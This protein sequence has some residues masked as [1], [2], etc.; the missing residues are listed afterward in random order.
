MVVVKL[1]HSIA[2]GAASRELLERIFGPERSALQSAEPDSEPSGNW[3][4]VVLML[5]G[6]HRT[7]VAL[8]SLFGGTLHQL[9]HQRT[10]TQAGLPRPRTAFSGATPPWG[11]DVTRS[12][13]IAVA[14]LPADSLRR[15]R[16]RYGASTTDVL[17]ALLGGTLRPSLPPGTELTAVV[18][19]NT[20]RGTDDEWGNHSSFSFRTLA[21]DCE[22]P[23]TRIA[24]TATEG[25]V[26]RKRRTVDGSRTVE[27]WWEAY[28]LC[29]AVRVLAEVTMR[30]VRGRV[31]AAA[32]VYTVAGPPSFDAGDA[33]VEQ[34]Y[35][36][37]PLANGILLNVTAWSYKDVL[38]IGVIVCPSDGLD[39]WRIAEAIQSQLSVL[40]R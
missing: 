6:A 16:E 3:Q 18:P 31:T 5:R 23:E 36:I 8:P 29:R 2:D 24:A 21:S 32:I 39:P 22:D 14:E 25:R 26:A 20:R 13:A 9:R 37:G 35:S 4:D 7:M 28:P 34:L 38:S 33:Q 1:H 40:D 15:V 27:T 11:M 19:V 10:L 12:R 30:F 17:I